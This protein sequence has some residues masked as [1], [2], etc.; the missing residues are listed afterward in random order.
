MA[1]NSNALKQ[2]E[3]IQ[4]IQHSEYSIFADENG[5]E[6]IKELLLP[7]NLQSSEQDFI[8]GKILILISYSILNPCP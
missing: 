7:E 5:F 2:C 8:N 4:W 3:V 1:E 6:N